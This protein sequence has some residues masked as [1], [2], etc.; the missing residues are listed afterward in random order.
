MDTVITCEQIL[1]SNWESILKS[2]E[3]RVC[4]DYYSAFKK[5]TEETSDQNQKQV[6]ALLGDICS[7]F[8]S[9][10]DRISLQPLWVHSNGNRSF[11]PADLPA[12]AGEE[13]YNFLQHI[14]D[15][16]LKAR[17]ADTIWISRKGTHKTETA[18]IA[19]QSYID[20][21]KGTTFPDIFETTQ[22]L[23]R[24][25][26]ISKEIGNPGNEIRKNVLDRIYSTLG[27]SNISEI[28]ASHYKLADLLFEN[29]HGDIAELGDLSQKF[30]E[31]SEKKTSFSLAR[32]FWWLAKKILA[33]CDKRDE[34]Y[35]AGLKACETYLKEASQTNSNI[36]KSFFL[37][38]A[39]QA[40][41]KIGGQQALVDDLHLELIEV[42][43]KSTSE[44]KT[45][46]TDGFDITELILDSKSKVSNKPL[47]EALINLSL[48]THP[49]NPEHIRTQIL[50]EDEHFSIFS[51]SGST[52]I[53]NKG[54]VVAKMRGIDPVS[55]A[56][57]EEYIS[58]RMHQNAKRQQSLEV[59]GCIVPARDQILLEHFIDE[60]DII[61]LLKN[62]PIIPEERGLLFAKGILAGFHSDYIIS[63]HILIP[64]LENFL[65]SII[66]F[67][68]GISSTLSS[69]GIQQEITLDRILE[70]KI[71]TN[72]FS[73]NTIFSLENLFINKFGSNLRNEMAHG[74]IEYDTFFSAQVVYLWWITLRICLLPTIDA[75]IKQKDCSET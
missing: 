58:Q 15:K 59:I 47:I 42:Q 29:K 8:F 66:E 52:Y 72:Y 30:A 48:I 62:N 75:H 4:S 39:I 9:D 7:T 6:M 35:H 53:N 73:K 38:N 67:H 60:H 11:S 36:A 34:A 33:Q 5:A 55:S 41:R 14:E 57:D 25:L 20:L 46:Q 21:T 56:Y 65:R 51:L 71:I 22:R 23:E 74:L 17:I 40:L 10:D 49:Q 19:I 50:K 54:K 32:D 18:I 69:S 1:R 16:E 12:E 64:Q 63:T 28:D 61:S 68:G 2:C 13:L 31:S 37:T 43:R 3:H 27:A 70:N 45:I 44:M 24:A 26:S